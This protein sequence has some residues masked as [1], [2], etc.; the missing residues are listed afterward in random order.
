MKIV[1]LVNENTSGLLQTIDN[2]RDNGNYHR[3][4]AV[5]KSLK[6]DYGG[7][8]IALTIGSQS[9]KSP[10]AF[11]PIPGVDKSISLV[12]GQ[13]YRGKAE[14][15]SEALSQL[16]FD[17]ALV[18]SHGED[19]ALGR[20]VAKALNLLHI[21]EIF[22]DNEISYTDFFSKENHQFIEPRQSATA[23]AKKQDGL[24]SKAVVKLP[25]VYTFYGKD[26]NGDNYGLY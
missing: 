14:L 13:V 11:S 8:I 7:D 3:T 22:D 21:K 25:C 9:A 15:F 4:F 6:E 20:S 24:R 26:M 17:I 19:G 23:K 2:N 10:Q 1:V 16:S 12:E 18:A 5:A